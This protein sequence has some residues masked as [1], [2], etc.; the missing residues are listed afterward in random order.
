MSEDSDFGGIWEDVE[1]EGFLVEET[2]DLKFEELRK[3]I[4]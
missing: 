4:H 2:L 1:R 3:L